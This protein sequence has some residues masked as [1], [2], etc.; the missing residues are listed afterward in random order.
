MSYVNRQ[1]K[2]DPPG[3]GRSR[4]SMHSTPADDNGEE[5]E[6]KQTN[7]EEGKM[8]AYICSAMPRHLTLPLL[9]LL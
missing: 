8:A 4:R 2:R 9:A 3:L 1:A 6:S 7:R 5:A